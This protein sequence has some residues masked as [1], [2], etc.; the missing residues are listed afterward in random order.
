[1][2][3]DE[4]IGIIRC[5]ACSVYIREKDP[6]SLIFKTT[7]SLHLEG[8]SVEG[9]QGFKSFPVPLNTKSI[10]GYVAVT[11][12]VVNIEDCYFIGDDCEYSF[13][14]A[15]DDKMNYRTKSMLAVPMKLKSGEVI[16]VLQ[17][18]NKLGFRADGSGLVVPFTAEHEGVVGSIASQMAISI[19]TNR[20]IEAQKFLLLSTVNSLT[21]AIESKSAHTAMHTKR[22]SAI[23]E[24]IVHA[25]HESTEGSYAHLRFTKA[26]R[27]EIKLAALLHDIGKITTPERILDKSNKLSE[28]QMALIRERFEILKHVEELK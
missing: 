4:I 12:E 24:G 1:M 21:D 20:L 26:E 6:D 15:Y 19:E 17:L 27:E 3:V 8:K 28:E 9:A 22:V 5:D 18:I 2:I 16:G 10:S 7:R 23:T 13:N 11:G 25:L 14:R